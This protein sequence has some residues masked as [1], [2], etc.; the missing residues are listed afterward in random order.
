M[1]ITVSGTDGF[2]NTVGTVGAFGALGIVSVAFNG[3][4]SPLLFFK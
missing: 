2:G 4:D 3:F 1:Q